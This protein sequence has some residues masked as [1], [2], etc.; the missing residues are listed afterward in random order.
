MAAAGDRRCPE[1]PVSTGRSV[2]DA[3]PRLSD[4]TLNVR[5][6]MMAIAVLG[7]CLAALR[8]QS[9]LGV[10]TICILCLAIVRTARATSLRNSL[11]S[12]MLPRDKVL[13]F[14]TSSCVA[15]ALIGTSDLAFLFMIGFLESLTVTVQSHPPIAMPA[16]WIMVASSVVATLVASRLGRVL[17]PIRGR[18]GKTLRRDFPLRQMPSD[19]V[20]P[21]ADARSPEP[22]R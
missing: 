6:L 4:F 12:P 2:A 14:V 3:P 5:V 22:G 13:L 15:T 20:G 1:S 16:P 21:E 9:A 10:V 17:W 11:G 8:A 18:L 19:P 7:A